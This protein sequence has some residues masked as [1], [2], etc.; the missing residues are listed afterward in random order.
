MDDQ[1]HIECAH[2]GYRRLPG[3]VRHRRQWLFNDKTLQVIDCLD[4]C[5]DSAQAYFHLHPDI[6]VQSDEPPQTGWF[7]LPDGQRMRWQVNMGNATIESSTYHPR[8]GQHQ[9]NHCLVVQLSSAQSQVCFT[10]T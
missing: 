4:G 5:F 9:P 8:F 7:L 10:W 3:R 6:V 2:E 1:L